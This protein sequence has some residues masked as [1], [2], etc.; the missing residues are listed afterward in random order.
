MRVSW[1]WWDFGLKL[2]I[3]LQRGHNALLVL[4]AAELGSRIDDID[5]ELHTHPLSVSTIFNSC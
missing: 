3:M 4:L 2:K 5:I 1:H